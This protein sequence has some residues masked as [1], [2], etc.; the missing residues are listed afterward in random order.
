MKLAVLLFFVWSV[1][2]RFRGTFQGKSFSSDTVTPSGKFHS[3][4][5]VASYTAIT[6]DGLFVFMLSTTPASLLMVL[7]GVSVY[8]VSRLLRNSAVKALGTQWNNHTSAKPVSRVVTLGPYQYTR[9]PYYSGTFLDLMAYSMIFQSL[10]TL[11]FSIAVYL[12]LLLNRVRLEEKYLS[13]KFPKAYKDYKSRTGLLFSFK[14]YLKDLSLVR[15]A[16]QI[17]E[18]VRKFGFNQLLRI[19]NMSRSVSRYSRGYAVSRIAGAMIEIGMVER[20]LR[21][22][23]LHIL[24]F[25]RQQ[26]LDFDTLKIISD[27]FA[28]L[29]ILEKQK[30]V[31]SLTPY[32]KTLFHDS[33]GA[34]TLLYAYMPV[35]ESLPEIIRKEKR[36]GIDLVRKSQFV[37]QGSNELAAL[38]PFPYAKDILGRHHLSRILDIGCG[39]GEFLINFCQG[40]GFYGFGIDLSPHVIKIAEENVAR[41]GGHARIRFRTG[42]VYALDKLDQEFKR[43]DV[44]TFMFVLHEFLEHGREGAI[45]VLK[46]V[47]H[48]FPDQHVLVTEVC[49]WSIPKLMEKPVAVAEHH[50]FHK[51]SHQGLATVKEWKSIFQEAGYQCVEEKRFDRAAQGYFLLKPRR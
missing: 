29:G 26:N 12:P 31:Y 15:D 42:D 7:I 16:S 24:N 50:L 34:L 39:A 47:K 8:L 4:I 32:G 23:N 18:I 30:F 2:D 17:F 40:D 27:Y 48:H 13:E 49:R 28:V 3:L 51:L 9:H 41:T 11:I 35:F 38:L 37:G 33:K 14:R 20:L 6:L 44:V 45:D 25:S 21:D 43:V 19:R 36:Y 1:V 22:G 5:M 10:R 46:R